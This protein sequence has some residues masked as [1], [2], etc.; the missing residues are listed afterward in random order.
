MSRAMIFAVA[1]LASL[2]PAA[3]YDFDNATCQT[4]LVGSWLNVHELGSHKVL[5]TVTFN[6]DGSANVSFAS[7][8]PDPKRSGSVPGTWHAERGDA[9]GACKMTMDRPS[10]GDQW[11]TEIPVI[12]ENTINIPSDS[13]A[14]TRYTRQP[15]E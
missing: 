2:P 5:M 13:G 1:G 8:P 3:A 7:D 11:V 4:F 6:A 10:R 15:A 14:E 12:D 9:F